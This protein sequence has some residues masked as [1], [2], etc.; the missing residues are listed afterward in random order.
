MIMNELEM[1]R[2]EVCECQ[3]CPSLVANRTQ[4]VFADGN[5]NSPILMVIGEA[6]GAT[7]DKKGLPFVGEAGELLDNIMKAC[8]WTRKDIYIANL[9]K[10]RPPDNRNPEPEE[11]ANCRG[12]LDRQI[13]LVKPKYILILG[14]VAS[15]VLIGNV[16]S[17]L[18][19]EWYSYRGVPSIITFHPAYLLRNPEEKR[20]VGADLRLLLTKMRA[21]GVLTT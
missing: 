17:S 19:G 13:D 3:K 8:G 15:R 6:P 1:V 7:E 5:P 18:R 20:L 16:V 14:S 11:V 9:V 4:T 21:D 10:C 12:Y 2:Q